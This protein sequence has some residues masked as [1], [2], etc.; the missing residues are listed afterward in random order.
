MEA[1]QVINVRIAAETGIVE[2]GAVL[3]DKGRI[4]AVD[5]EPSHA[6]KLK[7]ID[8]QGKLL[9]P[10]M[11]D[12]HIH[13][14]NG[15]DMMD[16][17]VKS[18]Q[19]VSKACAATGCTSFLATSVSSSL[20]D[21][22]AMVRQVKQVAGHEEGAQIAGIHIEGPYLNI[23]RKGMQNEAYLRHPDFT[24]ME[25]LIEQ[26][27]SLLKMV[28]IAPELPGGMEMVSYLHRQGIIA[29]IAHSDATYEEAKQAFRLGASHITHCFNGMRPIHHRD[30]GLITAALEEEKVSLQA[31][32]D[33][34]HL[35]PAMVRLM[36]RIK[37]PGG[38]VLITDA[39]QAMGLG[40][41][42][43]E[44]GGHRVTVVNGIAQLSDG[45]LASSTVTMNEALRN[46]AELGIPLHEAIV[47]ASTTPADV[48]GLS[49]KGRI[50]PGADADLVLLDGQFQ[51]EWT[52]IGGKE[53]YR[54][55]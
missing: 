4:I 53:V 23:K 39:L 28:T 55:M 3:I 14:A 48:L 30:P 10:G 45:T 42:Q 44:F 12:V 7:M 33:N 35:H 47:M 15:Y 20:E 24:E 41:G 29:A 51:V 34:V 1:I 2:N 13:G 54:R 40:D 38:M 49:N 43:Y 46:T 6:G 31:I 11:I 22:L 25:Q 18:I 19:E 9:I 50:A 52:M 36:H 37:G 5:C 32:V 21:L 16:G 26:A 17:T 8:G 27:G